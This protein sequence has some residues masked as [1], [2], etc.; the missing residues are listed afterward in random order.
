[1][2]SGAK[3]KSLSILKNKEKNNKEELLDQ[4]KRTKNPVII[5]PDIADNEI[6][7]A[8]LGLYSILKEKN[9]KVSLVS[10]KKPGPKLAFLENINE[11]KEKIDST[12]SFVLSFDTSK[13]E[14][15][16][17]QYERVRNKLNIYVTPQKGTIDPKDFY[18]ASGQFKYDLV[19]ILGAVELQ[20]VGICYEKN[21]DLFFDLPVVNIDYHIANEQ[22]GQIN[23][24]EVK[25]SG[26]SEIIAEIFNNIGVSLPQAATDCF[27]T[28]ILE[29]TE[30]FQSPRTTPKTLMTA[31]NLIDKGANYKE[32]VRK[33]YKTQNL[34]SIKLW[35][36]LMA[37]I[38]E[39]TSL[40][41]AWITAQ[42]EDFANTKMTTIQLRSIFD[43]I[44][45]NYNKTGT[46]M[47]LW[48]NRNGFTKG[49]IQNSNQ[50]FFRDLFKGVQWG[51][52]VIFEI[53]E[54][55]S[56]A[57]EKILKTLKENSQQF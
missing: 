33:L 57:E 6:T 19:I 27:Y 35:G 7:C 11:I 22:Y 15:K 1:M 14:I 55:L 56:R 49:L 43:K 13:N 36:R 52:A 40:N 42:K 5:L 17:V 39:D 37:K 38:K 18:L 45:N 44:R 30:S 29:A 50:E 25:S 9:K 2:L 23:V 53:N 26:V 28:G 47:L 54:I 46:L 34:D 3:V 48:E 51:N 10:Y 20:D 24:V 31:A 41:L 32:I 12:R 21:A 8:G 4:I 16:N